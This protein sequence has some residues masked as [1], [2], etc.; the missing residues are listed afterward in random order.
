MSRFG[1]VG[2][3]TKDLGAL[4][5]LPCSD[6]QC[7]R[8]FHLKRHT[9]SIGILFIRFLKSTTWRLHCENCDYPVSIPEDA[10][11]KCVQF[12]ATAQK[13]RDGRMQR[14]E[15]LKQLRAAHFAFVDLAVQTNTTWAC[16]S[17]GEESPLTMTSCWN[18]NGESPDTAPVDNID[19]RNVP[20]LNDV[21]RTTTADPLGPLNM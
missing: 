21:M 11:E 16:P 3:D 20:Y 19:N 1:E 18:C 15:F 2:G 17:C 5:L 8:W 4:A 7:V 9:A 14:D 12:L 6:C 13:C 10:P